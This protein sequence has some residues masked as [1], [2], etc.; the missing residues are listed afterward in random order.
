MHHRGPAGYAVLLRELSARRRRWLA[1]I[2]AALCLLPLAIYSLRVPN[3]ADG[4]IAQAARW[5]HQHDP[6]VE[7]KALLGGKSQRRL[8]FY[9]N[10]HMQYWPENEPTLDR[11][12]AELRAHL[13]G[14]RPDYFAI[15]SG[16]GEERAG[17]DQLLERLR[18]DEQVAAH[19]AEVHV[20][21]T[22]R[23]DALHIWRF[24][25]E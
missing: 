13:V 10:M 16:P 3:G 6:P 9:A 25:W 14:S 15:E 20:Q 5:L 12:F 22:P 7:S 1:R 11:R 17:N 8:A 19:A 21:R 4:F 23:G 2:F 18:A 24:E